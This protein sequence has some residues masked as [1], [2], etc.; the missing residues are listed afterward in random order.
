[1]PRLR[2][3]RRLGLD[4]HRTPDRFDRNDRP[5]GVEVNPQ[6]YPTLECDRPE[7]LAMLKL[8][9]HVHD[10]PPPPGASSGDSGSVPFHSVEG[11]PVCAEPRE[12]DAERLRTATSGE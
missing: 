1:L 4:H 7:F 6:S 10:R 3:R 9:V 5:D 8:Q 11:P 12:L 2:K